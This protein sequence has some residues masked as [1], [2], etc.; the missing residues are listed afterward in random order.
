MTE[1]IPHLRLRINAR[2]L[3]KLEKAAEKNRLTLTGE[4]VER[5]AASFRKEDTR[6]QLATMAALV[7]RTIIETVANNKAR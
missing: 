3:A 1:H 2:L 4:I 5:L 6:M 7:E